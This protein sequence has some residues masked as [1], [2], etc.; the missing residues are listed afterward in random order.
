M[1][2]K[3]IKIT[4]IILLIAILLSGCG[5]PSVVPDDAQL[6]EDY[7]TLLADYNNLTLNAERLE[8]ANAELTSNQEKCNELINAYSSLQTKYAILESYYNN[9]QEQYNALLPQIGVQ[10]IEKDKAMKELAQQYAISENRLRLITN[11][12]EAVRSK[13]VPLL[14]ANLTDIEYNA[15][16]KGWELWWGEFND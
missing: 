13:N 11:Q 4:I 10:N 8:K 16:Y 1:K 15:F 7:A 5:S 2:R 3:L 6:K 14:S 12:I 9:L